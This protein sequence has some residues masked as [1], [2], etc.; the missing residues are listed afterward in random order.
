VEEKIKRFEFFSSLKPI[1]HESKPTLE[2]VLGL[3]GH[4]EYCKENCKA[5]PHLWAADNSA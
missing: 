1:N 2:R 4:K 5:A 3:M